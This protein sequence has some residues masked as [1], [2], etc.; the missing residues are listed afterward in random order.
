MNFKRRIITCSISCLVAVELIV[1]RVDNCDVR[2]DITK[3]PNPSKRRELADLRK[4]RPV[5]N[6]LPPS[7]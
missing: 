7:H 3:F 1:C 2:S 6:P 4:Y 5:V